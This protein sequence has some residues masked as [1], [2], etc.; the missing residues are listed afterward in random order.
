[1][2]VLHVLPSLS[3]SRGGPSAAMRSLAAALVKAGCDVDVAST[4]DQA[5]G[6]RDGQ[7]KNALK[8]DGVVY[9]YFR[10][11]LGFYTVSF[12]LT[13]WV[14]AHASDYDVIHTHYL[15][16][17]TS[18]A[19]ARIAERQGVPYVVRPV[20]SLN[21]WGMTRRR[22]LMKK[23]SFSALE[24]RVVRNAAAIHLT[25]H[26]EL[27]ETSQVAAIPQAV[28]I[29]NP[30]ELPAGDRPDGSWSDRID[31]V[32]A[33]NRIVLFLS[34]IDAMKGLDLLIPAFAS[35]LDREPQTLLMIAGAGSPRLVRSLKVLTKEL[36]IEANVYWAGFVDDA[37]KGYLLRKSDV[38]VLPS[39]SESFGIAA[40]EALG[41]GLPVVVT[42]GVGVQEE[43]ASAGA[44]LVS[45]ATSAELADAM[46]LLLS[47]D[48]LASSFR[49]KGP[50][51]AKRFAPKRVADLVIDLYSSIL[52]R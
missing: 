37:Q 6:F 29:P 33:G 1:M 10:K 20:G 14:R 12:P 34:R 5:P 4:D 27:L 26:Q 17:H 19:A 9:R 45:G 8:E 35:R 3:P 43:I 38:F 41:V 31:S 50:E 40:I 23:I 2:R 21:T 36:G 11:Q 15:F 47:D 32:T 28:I 18:V 39:R 30:V 48:S 16:T 13:S 7:S 42:A 46:D 24:R 52:S 44:G 22:P 25:S 49:L 51:L